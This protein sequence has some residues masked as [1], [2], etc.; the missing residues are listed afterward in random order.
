MII[1]ICFLIVIILILKEK[2]GV[3]T[4]LKRQNVTLTL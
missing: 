1:K 3:L 2:V 4:D